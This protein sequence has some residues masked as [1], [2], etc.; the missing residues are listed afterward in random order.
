MLIMTEIEILKTL[1]SSKEPAIRLKTYLKLLDHDYE[2]KE[3]KNL[4]LNLSHPIISF[5]PTLSPQP[6]SPT[7]RPRSLIPLSPR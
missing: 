3:V 7:P 2:T 4:T 1:L 6:S 5:L